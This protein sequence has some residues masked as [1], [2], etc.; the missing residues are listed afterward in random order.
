MTYVSHSANTWV[1]VFDVTN[2]TQSFQHYLLWVSPVCF[3]VN[4]ESGLSNGSGAECMT[5]DWAE[6]QE[7]F[8]ILERGGWKRE[9]WTNEFGDL[10]GR[11][12][13]VS[14]SS[15][16]VQNENTGKIKTHWLHLKMVAAEFYCLVLNTGSLCVDKTGL[17]LTEICPFL[18][19][20]GWD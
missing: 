18:P 9:V 15:T 8:F 19:P 3:L 11:W 4:S 16:H 10:K 7:D 20:E 6:V 13:L 2:D 14:N 17:K 12:E 1:S 5:W